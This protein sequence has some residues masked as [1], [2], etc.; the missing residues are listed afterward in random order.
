MKTRIGIVGLGNISGIYLENLTGMFSGRVEIGGVADLLPQ[1]A[2]KAAG[3]Y[4]V[5]AMTVEELLGSEKIDLILNLTIPQ[6]HVE[7]YDR[8]LDAGKHVYGEK[9]FSIERGDAIRLLKKAEGKDLVMG[10]APD[11]FLGGGIQTCAKLIEDG[12]IGRPVAATA[13][14]TCHGHEGW[15]PNP[16]FYYKK[17]GGPMFD[18]GPYYLTALVALLGPISR[19]SGSARKSF[20]TR[21]ITSR[22]KCGTVIDVEVPTHIAGTIDFA[23]GAVGTIIT[24]FDIWHAH[25]P[26]IEIYGSEGT[27]RVPDPNTFG[28]PVLLRRHDQ[29]EWAEIPLTHGYSENSRGLGVTE[30]AAAIQEKRTPRAS[31]TL[32]AHVVDAMTGF[33]T[34][35]E[36]AQYH[37]M[38]VKTD[39]PALLPMSG[40]V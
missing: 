15:H 6:A 37:D 16:E 38:E 22:P 2:E 32:A 30:M 9:P 8:A 33:H 18:M 19:V 12:W 7:I 36:S 29:P 14:M 1:R 20:P 5:K 21:R 31:G 13:F 17:G 11:T 26:N 10:S 4:G 28:G 23:N 40:I 35:S 3:E 27:L 39:K 25:L 34:A 24:S